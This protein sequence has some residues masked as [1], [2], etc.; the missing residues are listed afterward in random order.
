VPASAILTLLIAVCDHVASLDDGSS[1][2]RM[3]K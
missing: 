3:L 2:V 1:S